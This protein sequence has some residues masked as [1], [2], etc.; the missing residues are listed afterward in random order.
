[1]GGAFTAVAD[2][3]SA[4]FWNPAGFATGSFFSLVDRRAAHASIDRSGLAV[5]A[6]DPAAGP[7]YYRTAIAERKERPKYARSAPCRRVAGA[8]PR[9]T[10]GGRDH[11]EVACTGSPIR[12]R[13]R[14]R[15][16]STN[17]FDADVGVMADRRAGPTGSV[18]AEPVRAGVRRRRRGDPP[19]SA[20]P[21]RG[22]DHAT[23]GQ[24]RSPPTV[25][26]T[27]AATPRGIGGTRRSGWRRSR[28]SAWLR[29]GVHWNTVG[30]IGP[31]GRRRSA[32]LGGQLA[33]YGST[34]ADA[35]VSFGSRRA[36]G[37]GD[38]AAV[39]LLA[40]E[41]FQFINFFA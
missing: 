24:P 10:P 18:G 5:A 36:T 34:I 6:G 12:R 32:A 19:R 31:S 15:V 8:V 4:A 21:G 35:Q 41:S 7:S 14:R 11:A 2:D 28:G 17:K 20:G 37:A 22:V 33:V 23:P 16:S 38:R 25:D 39:R 9:R 3:G 27:T 13:R 1:M 40:A 26:L 29:G 30:R